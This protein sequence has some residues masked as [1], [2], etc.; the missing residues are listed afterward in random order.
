M[1]TSGSSPLAGALLAAVAIGAALSLSAGPA[2]ASLYCE[3]AEASDGFAALRAAPDRG[4]RLLEKMTPADDIQ[5]LDRKGRWIRVAFWRGGR[6]DP[7]TGTPRR[8]TAEGWMHDS[9]L[10][11]D[12]CG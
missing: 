8:A 5:L 3:I 11:P 2:R 12:S 1:T 9:L 6:L 10:V 7:A 4:A